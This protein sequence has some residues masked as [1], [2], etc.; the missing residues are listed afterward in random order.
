MPEPNWSVLSSEGWHFKDS[1]D[2]LMG[3]FSSLA[4]NYP[5]YARA[6]FEYANALDYC[7]QESLAIDHYQT[8]LDQG[9][10]QPYDLYTM[11]QL[12]SSY[13]NV[14][15]Y[16]DAVAILE[17]ALNLNPND[18]STVMFYSL[19]LHSAGRGTDALKATLTYILSNTHD[20]EQ[21]RYGEPLKR[22]IDNLAPR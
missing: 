11:I 16:D 15:R 20:K 19:A 9:I 10:G 3:Y 17:Q 5:Q 4:A 13:R 14:E 22:Y 18:A 2:E 12:G 7:G 1:P 6:H 8:A 21:L